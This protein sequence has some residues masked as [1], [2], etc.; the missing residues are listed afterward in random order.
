MT[1]L[2][3]L[4]FCLG[5]LVGSGAFFRN[6]GEK[7]ATYVLFPILFVTLIVG[8]KAQDN[9]LFFSQI[10]KAALYGALLGLSLLIG[11][12]AARIR[13][14]GG[15]SFAGLVPNLRL[16]F[17][18]LWTA[19][20]SRAGATRARARTASTVYYQT[21]IKLGA[22]TTA[23]DKTRAADGFA[24]IKATFNLNRSTCPEALD[25]FNIQMRHPQRLGAV[26]DPFLNQYGLGSTI[27]ETLIFGMCK[28]A[29]ADG[30]ASVAEIRLIDRVAHR[31]GLPPIDTRRIIA[32]A[33]V[34][35]DDGFKAHNKSWQERMRDGARWGSQQNSGS[36]TQNDTPWR[37]E[38]ETHLATLG[39]PA[40]AS[41]KDAKSAWRKLAKKYHPDKLISQNLPADEMAKAEAMMQTINE[42]YDWL[43]ENP[44]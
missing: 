10:N 11:Y 12:H 32:S 2:S 20:T 26:L 44:R 9:E 34:P 39:L 7:L 15:L 38:R 33:G 41:G 37:G 5:I 24:V 25:V 31:L 22:M 27:A 4:I 40:N 28:V 14:Q 13:H 18:S 21:A 17:R 36:G 1:G 42:A 35:I 19:D 3:F 16:N 30:T 43:K 6:G 23:I 8:L 29:L